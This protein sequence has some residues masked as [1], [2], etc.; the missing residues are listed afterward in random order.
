MDLNS[1]FSK[2]ISILPRRRKLIVLLFYQTNL[3][4]HF[5]YFDC[6]LR[7]AVDSSCSSQKEKGPH[8]KKVRYLHDSLSLSLMVPLTTKCQKIG[9]KIGASC[10]PQGIKQLESNLSFMCKERH[11]GRGMTSVMTWQSLTWIQIVT[12]PLIQ[13]QPPIHPSAILLHQG[14]SFYQL[15]F[16]ISLLQT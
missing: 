13:L 7:G 11:F 2:V 1:D 4:C 9:E 6:L 10:L 14:I 8:F 15:F 5:Q 3:E 16:L 12:H